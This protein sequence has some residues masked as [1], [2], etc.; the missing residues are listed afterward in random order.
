MIDFCRHV[1][2]SERFQT[3]ILFLILLTSASIGLETI[4]EM[5]EQFDLFFLAMYYVAQAVF[6]FE[7]FVRVMAHAPAVT[8][9]F[10]R[11]S[12]TFDFLIVTLSFLPG[13]GSF[14]LVARTLRI[15]RIFSVSNRMRV[16][17]DRLKDSF[18]EAV[19]TAFVT[20]IVG[21]IFA[22][23]GFY[24]F[25]VIDPAH[26]ETLSKSAVSVFYLLLLQDIPAIA[27]PL[28]QA[29]MA[30]F[31]YFLLFYFV[32]VSLFISV[33]AACVRDGNTCKSDVA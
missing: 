9:F 5:V 16:F 32:F 20:L 17:L 18:D 10:K 31:F 1:A 7:I 28:L 14:A 22:I 13:I 29:S 24:L 8:Y 6:T 27:G 15:L 19:Y 21:Y 23:S 11:R 12:N 4:P 2:D 30:Y 3:F 25:S 26:W 33:I